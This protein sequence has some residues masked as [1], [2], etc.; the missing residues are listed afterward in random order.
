VVSVEIFKA[1]D[2]GDPIPG[3]V[4]TYTYNS[5]DPADCSDE[6]PNCG[7]WNCTIQYPPADRQVLVG[8]TQPP[9]DLVG[10]RIVYTH[11]WMTGFPPFNGSISIDER[12]ISR[13]EPA[14]FG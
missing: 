13:L 2:S 9:L 12:T 10:M 8:G 4:N 1:D 7:A 11:D 3:S 14:G 6:A 5:G